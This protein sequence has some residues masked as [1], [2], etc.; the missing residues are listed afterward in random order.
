MPVLILCA[1]LSMPSV[2]LVSTVVPVD[3]VCCSCFS[4]SAIAWYVISSLSLRL[5][6]T[7]RPRAAGTTS[8]RLASASRA[9]AEASRLL[10]TLVLAVDVR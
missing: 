6:Q 9:S 1:S 3:L 4:V 10:H 8:V 7:R 5:V 2:L